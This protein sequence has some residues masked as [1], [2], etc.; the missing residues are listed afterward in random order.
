MEVA[1]AAGGWLGLKESLRIPE[2]L[3]DDVD[4]AVP[5][6]DGAGDSQEARGLDEDHVLL[7]DPVKGVK[8]DVLD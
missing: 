6:L 4:D 7:E 8:G 2:G 1:A 5:L 3:R